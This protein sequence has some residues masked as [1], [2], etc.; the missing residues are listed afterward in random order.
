MLCRT[1]EWE[2]KT[3]IVTALLLTSKES[4]RLEKSPLFICASVCPVLK[5]GSASLVKQFK[6]KLKLATLHF[7]ETFTLCRPPQ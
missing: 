3:S 6:L 5:M 1:L 4:L 2:S 7:L